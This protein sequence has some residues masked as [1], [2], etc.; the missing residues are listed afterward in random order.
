MNKNTKTKD[1]L[2]TAKAEIESLRRRNEILQ[3]KVEVMNLFVCVLHTSP[4]IHN[5]P[6]GIDVAWELG[7][8]IARMEQ[9]E[10][11]ANTRKS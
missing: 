5:P 8:E 3:A 9:D 7:R 1:T 6:M 10:V 4:A 2:I 11:L